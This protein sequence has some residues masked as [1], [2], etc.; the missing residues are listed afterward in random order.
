[1]NNITICAKYKG[2][3]TTERGFRT[4]LFEI[5]PTGGK[6]PIPVPITL[7]PSLAAQDSCAAGRYAEGTHIIINGRIYPHLEDG[8]LY[9]VP[10]QP[11]ESLKMPVNLNQVNLAGQVGYIGEQRRE[12]AFN[13]GMMVQAPPQKSIG[14]TWQDSLGFKVESWGDDAE[15]MKKLLFVGRAISLGGTLKFESWVDRDGNRRNNYKIRVRSMQYAFFGKNQKTE[16]IEK[17]I[18]KEVKE[19]INT[20]TYVKEDVDDQVPF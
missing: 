6:K 19:I 2:D 9:V 10:T 4:M 7:I 8:K 15:R 1:M 13:F 16:D 5:P 11:L 3:S 17:K 14:H 12:D 20:K 18:D